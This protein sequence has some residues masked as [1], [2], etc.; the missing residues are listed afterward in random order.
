MVRHK[1]FKDDRSFQEFLL[2]FAPSDVYYSSAYFERPEAEMDVKGWLGADLIFDIDADHIPTEC[3]KRHDMWVCKNCGASGQGIEPHECP[4]CAGQKFSELGW[5]CEACLESAKKETIKLV[6]V[7]ERDFGFALKE[8]KLAFSGH[9]GYHIHIED[10]AV[11]TLDSMARKEIVDYMA[12]TGIE[13]AMYDLEKGY[14]PS[15]KDSG[16]SGRIAKGAYD[17]M[18]SATQEQL[19][20]AG[21]KRKRAAEI[22]RQKG[23]LLGTWKE[24]VPGKILRVVGHD[25]WKKLLQQS[26]TRQS[27]KIDSVVTTDVHRLIRLSN[28]IH[29]ETGLKKVEFCVG[30]IERFDPLKSA[31]AFTH[32]TISLEVAEAPQFRLRDTIYGP[33][34]NQKVE[35][36]AAAAMFLL[37][38]GVAGVLEESVSVQ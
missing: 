33:F 24:R 22:V 10:P 13:L 20:N 23:E 31:L 8:L 26:I 3:D 36:P 37:C 6:D 9:R 1:G 38:K 5:L 35:L 21:L 27:V 12:G 28:T 4:K 25:S 19:E 2:K 32:G 15:L 16:W 11:R 7:L 29:G 30:E 17:F 14:G 34:K 18:L